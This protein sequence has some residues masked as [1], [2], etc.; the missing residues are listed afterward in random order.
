MPTQGESAELTAVTMEL[1][2]IPPFRLDH[3][4]W[5]LRRRSE[6][7]VDRWDGACYSRVLLLGGRPTEVHVSQRGSPEKPRLAVR[8]IG[9][10][11]TSQAKSEAARILRRMLGLETDLT[12]FYRLAARDNRLRPLVERYHGLKPVRFPTVFEALANAIACQQ[13]TL[14]AGLRLLGE[15]ARRGRVRLATPTGVHYGFPQPGDILR[16]PPRTFRRLGFS[17]QKTV[18]LRELSRAVLQGRFPGEALDA[19]DNDSAIHVLLEF[20]GVGRWSAEYALLRGL[21]RWD[22]FPADDVGAQKGLARWLHLPRPMD[23]D[24]VRRVLRPWQPYAGLIYFHL[25]LESL[26]ARQA[27]VASRR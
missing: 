25:L 14:V 6:N 12:A 17:H 27:G 15:L 24:R 4:A 5:A 18:A 20:H 7:L 22:V 8:V 3:T 21:G 16:L 9:E 11:V 10:H 2:P 13:F 1:I 19:Q 23:S 26:R